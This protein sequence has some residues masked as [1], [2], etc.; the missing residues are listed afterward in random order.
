MDRSFQLSWRSS[1]GLGSVGRGYQGAS[2]HPQGASSTSQCP[3]QT[4]CSRATY[5][6]PSSQGLTLHESFCF[7]GLIQLGTALGVSCAAGATCS[8]TQPWHRALAVPVVPAGS[9]G[10]PDPLAGGTKLRCRELEL[11]TRDT[12][13]RKA[14]S[15]HPG[16]SFCSSFLLL[17]KLSK[18]AG[19]KKNPNSKR[20]ILKDL[21]ALGRKG[22]PGKEIWNNPDFSSIIQQLPGGGKVGSGIFLRAGVPWRA[23]AAP[24]AGGELDTGTCWCWL[25]V[26]QGLSSPWSVPWWAGALLPYSSQVL[27]EK[28]IGNCI[29]YGDVLTNITLGVWSSQIH[30]L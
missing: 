17:E 8:G 15:T 23:G 13:G 26:F 24:W 18:K 25:P 16:F 2:E 20:H 14:S 22:L 19:K 28:K 3:I 11:Q 5:W 9:P 21:G 12:G 6:I 30:L 27:C 7:M 29:N 1:L 10:N 4:S